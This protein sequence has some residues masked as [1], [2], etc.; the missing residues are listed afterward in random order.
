[1]V[2]ARALRSNQPDEDAET[3]DLL[4]PASPQLRRLLADNREA[5]RRGTT[6]TVALGAGALEAVGSFFRDAFPE[7]EAVVGSDE[8]ALEAAGVR[9]RRVVLEPRPGDD[10]LVAED[11]VITA[12]QTL[13]AAG[14]GIA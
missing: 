6:R 2:S 3:M 8:A 13:L 5:G 11:G 12:F 1:M 4:E 7:R 14:H 10:H 9:A